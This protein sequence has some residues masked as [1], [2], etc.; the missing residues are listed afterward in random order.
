MCQTDKSSPAC[1][2][3]A[4]LLHILIPWQAFEECPRRQQLKHRNGLGIN[5]STLY[6]LYPIFKDVGYV[7]LM[8]VSTYRGTR[9]FLR[10][11]NSFLTEI[12]PLGL[13]I[14]SRSSSEPPLIQGHIS[15]H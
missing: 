4:H 1:P 5:R 15:S 6:M 9:A 2:L 11:L 8:K 7:V 10:L 13:K 14:S 12:T 3:C